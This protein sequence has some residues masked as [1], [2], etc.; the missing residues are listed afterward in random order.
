MEL[1]IENTLQIC[2]C[3]NFENTNQNLSRLDMGNSGLVAEC[4]L[5]F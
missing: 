5:P 3:V 1:A 2:L 4:N